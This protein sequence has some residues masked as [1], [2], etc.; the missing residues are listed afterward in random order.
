MTKENPEE[1]HICRPGYESG[2]MFQRE[3]VFLYASK[4]KTP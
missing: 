4:V 3:R 2:G 1:G